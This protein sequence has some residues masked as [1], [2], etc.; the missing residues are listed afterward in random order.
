MEK[1][2]ATAW[3]QY[4]TFYI[5]GEE[6]GVDI[7]QVQEI[8]GI[9]SI[10]RVPNLPAWIKGVANMRGTIVPVADLG[11]RLGRPAAGGD[12]RTAMIILR[13]DE[14]YVGFAIDAMGDILSI[15]PESLFSA[16]EMAQSG[17]NEM[18]ARIGRVD[19]RSIMMLDPSKIFL[20]LFARQ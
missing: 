4:I 11:A 18:I 16:E 2:G 5:A 14:G 20:H 9:P 6:Y 7:L 1:D 8:T 19:D 15:A 17:R 12:G 3:G 13:A 10:T